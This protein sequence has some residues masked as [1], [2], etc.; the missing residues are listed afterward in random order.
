MT[1]VNKWVD[2]ASESITDTPADGISGLAL[3]FYQWLS[4]L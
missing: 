4:T 2:E 3:R 1:G